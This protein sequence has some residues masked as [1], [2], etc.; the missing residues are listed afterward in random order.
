MF[1]ILIGWQMSKVYLEVRDDRSQDA[2]HSQ[3]REC[4]QKGEV[5]M[6]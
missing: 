6:V 5:F 1:V 3:T 2:L 4:L